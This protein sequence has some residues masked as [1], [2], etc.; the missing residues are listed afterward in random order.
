MRGGAVTFGHS[1]DVVTGQL[2]LQ[3]VLANFAQDRVCCLNT[4]SVEFSTKLI[5]K[6]DSSL[7]EAKLGLVR[8]G[9]EYI[10]ANL[11]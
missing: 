3:M 4:G 6:F 7:V 1:R 2:I 10:I 5:K 9:A 11:D 8:D